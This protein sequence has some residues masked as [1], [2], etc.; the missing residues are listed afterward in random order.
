MPRRL[1]V[2]FGLVLCGCGAAEDAQKSEPPAPVTAFV[3][4]NVI[5]MDREGVLESQTVIVRGDRIQ[6]VGPVSRVKVP[7]SAVVID[8]KGKYLLPG[9]A[10]MHAHIDD[11]DYLFLFVANGVTTIRNMW[12]GPEHLEWRRRMAECELAAPTIYTAGPIIDGDPPVFPESVVITTPAEAR[13]TARK[14]KAAGY[15]FLKVYNNLS[16]EAYDALILAAQEE[17]I[18]VAGHVPLKVGLEHVLESGQRCIE[19]LDGY[20]I[21]LAADWCT[22]MEGGGF[23]ALL[24]PWLEMDVDKIPDIVRKTREAGAWNCPTL[25]VYQKWVPAGRATEL[26]R[27]TEFTYLSPSELEY[28]NPE[29]SYLQSFTPELFAA[30][31]AGD[32]ARMVVTKALHDGGARILLGTDC[33]NPLVV[34]GF[35]L[36]EELS[37]FVGRVSRIVAHRRSV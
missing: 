21:P 10:D 19:H 1:L 32:P 31:A 12:G 16:L 28:H 34:Y 25:V 13:E 20:E 27:Q 23:A 24:L 3:N 22:S 36:H 29:T 26:L 9:L 6:E 17:N 2:V 18:P 37:N 15:D 11:E 8:G 30:A 35:S 33:G 14:Q 4:V 7:G 5:P